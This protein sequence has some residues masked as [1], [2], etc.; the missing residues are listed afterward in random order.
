MP[1]KNITFRLYMYLNLCSIYMT[2]QV[3]SCPSDYLQWQ[4]TM[5][6][7]FG[8]K[9][10]RLHHG[11]GWSVVQTGQDTTLAERG[12]RNPLEVQK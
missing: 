6:N 4:Q 5:Y 7:V 8:T 1:A 2:L 10:L 11:R 12:V 3:P 9:W